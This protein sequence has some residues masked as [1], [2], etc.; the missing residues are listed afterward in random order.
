MIASAIRGTRERMLRAQRLIRETPGALSK[1][2]SSR[3]HES[4]PF[5][6]VFRRTVGKSPS[7]FRDALPE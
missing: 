1:S 6:P 5:R 2:A 7:D 4:K 3:L